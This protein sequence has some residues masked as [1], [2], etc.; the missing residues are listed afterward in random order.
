MSSANR[1]YGVASET[2][3]YQK[4]TTPSYFD[5]DLSTTVP[6]P[7]LYDNNTLDI[8]I[9]DN[10]QADFIDDGDSPAFDTEYQCTVMGGSGLVLHLGP[11]MKEWLNSWLSNNYAGDYDTDSCAVHNSGVM[12]KAQFVLENNADNELLESDIDDSTYA[13]TDSVPIGK[14]SSN[15]VFGGDSNNFRTTWIFR[16]PLV[17]SFTVLGSKK[18]LT[19]F[20]N[21]APW[22]NLDF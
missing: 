12:T 8:N 14:Y 22:G 9:Q 18:Y 2:T 4:V 15:Y 6:I 17:I 11:K 7:F 19:L 20:T 16:S 1:S 3:K 5:G 13:I 10:V 21:F